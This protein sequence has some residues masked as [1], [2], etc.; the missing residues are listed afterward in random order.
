MEPNTLEAL[1]RGVKTWSFQPKQLSFLPEVLSTKTAESWGFFLKNRA[2]TEKK[3]G[4]CGCLC[5]DWL[6]LFPLKHT[7]D[8]K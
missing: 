6:K 1:A 5:C 7:E 3:V 4:V 8:I 2:F